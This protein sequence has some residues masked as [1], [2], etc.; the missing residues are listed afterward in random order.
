MNLSTVQWLS[1]VLLDVL[2]KFVL[3]TAVGLLVTYGL[4]SIAML[5]MAAISLSMLHFV[6]LFVGATLVVMPELFGV[7]FSPRLR[8]TLGVA[9]ANILF[10]GVLVVMMWPGP[11][12][13]PR[14][15]DGPISVALVLAATNLVAF[16]AVAAAS[17][18]FRWIKPGSGAGESPPGV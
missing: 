7:R 15:A 1:I 9:L 8:F 10:V 14:T 5:V 12:D 3:V 17:R 4:I 13:I 2:I 16:F 18:L 6:C 11:H